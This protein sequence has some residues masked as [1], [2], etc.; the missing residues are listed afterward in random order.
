MDME[1]AR[2]LDGLGTKRD[3]ILQRIIETAG[4]DDRVVAVWLTGSFGRGE[5]D[6]W[7]DLDLH[8][9]IDD[10]CLDAW[11]RSRDAFYRQIAPPL[12]ILPERISNAQE[13]AR[14]QLVSFPGP[15]EVDWNI[16]PVGVATRPSTSRVLFARQDIPVARPL[17][18]D[19]DTRRDRL[20]WATDYFWAMT[21][22]AVKYAGRGATT[23]AVDQI[24]L[25]STRG[26]T[27][28]WRGVHA[29]PSLSSP[30]PRV[31][32]GL[33]AILPILDPVIDSSRC[34]EAIV[35]AMSAMVALKPELDAAGVRWP[36]AM[37]PQVEALVEVARRAIEQRSDDA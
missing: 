13:D 5:A 1:A 21:P 14:M 31:E 18:L 2:T 35:S 8:L 10:A 33:A 25:L 4:K 36:A 29:S 7:S 23:R 17:P 19:P 6:A 15:V 12:L 34:L 30:N 32:P 16:G 22:I 24:K 26:L 28:V 3:D 27:E 9:A 20:Q 37:V 11:W